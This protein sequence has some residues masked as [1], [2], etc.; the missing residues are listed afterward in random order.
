[1]GPDFGKLTIY[2]GKELKELYKKQKK[3][4]KNLKRT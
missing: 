2:L 1:M 3:Q 4:Y